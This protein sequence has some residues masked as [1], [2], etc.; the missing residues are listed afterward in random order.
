MNSLR[1]GFSLAFDLFAYSLIAVVGRGRVVSECARWLDYD[2]DLP[3]FRESGSLLQRHGGC[4]A[5]LEVSV[6]SLAADLGEG[7]ITV[8]ASSAGP[9]KALAALGILEFRNMLAVFA[10]KTLLKR[11]VTPEALA[12]AGLILPGL[13]KSGVVGEALYVDCGFNIIAS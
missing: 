10:A 3:G 7:G 12:N 13:L 8:D 1:S 5:A 4:N 2:F 9:I 6:R 11:N